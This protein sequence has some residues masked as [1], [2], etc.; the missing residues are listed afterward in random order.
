M[1][2]IVGITFRIIYFILFLQMNNKNTDNQNPP[3]L[4]EL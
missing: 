2:N 4:K 1:D 3:K